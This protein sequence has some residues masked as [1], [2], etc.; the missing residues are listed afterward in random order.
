VRPFRESAQSAVFPEVS[1]G[2]RALRRWGSSAIGTAISGMVA[3]CVQSDTSRPCGRCTFPGPDF[4]RHSFGNGRACVDALDPVGYTLGMALPT[5]K[6]IVGYVRVSTS[7]Q[8]EDGFSIS[9]QRERIAQYVKAL[10]LG[11][12]VEIIVDEGESAKDLKRPGMERLLGMIRRREIDMV[13][14]AKLD[15]ATRSMRDLLGLLSTFERYRVE[16]ASIAERLDTS[17]ASG[18]FFVGMLGLV[19]EWEL[20]RTRERTAEVARKLTRDGRAISRTAPYGGRLVSREI[21]TSKG[22]AMRQ[23]VEADPERRSELE[24][25]ALARSLRSE[26]ISIGEI[27]KRI[28][29]AGFRNRNGSPYAKGSIARMLSD[30]LGPSLDHR[31]RKAGRVRIASIEA[32][33]A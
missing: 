19:A 28:F 23:F 10:D 20:E 9:V 5:P 7:R 4:V 33:A 26:G 27:R 6:R 31:G 32:V 18:R 25:V 13:V 22:P 24:A 2:F 15:R 30:D 21:M 12:L 16:F 11:D 17:S 1:D 3:V 29:E 14:V 8:A